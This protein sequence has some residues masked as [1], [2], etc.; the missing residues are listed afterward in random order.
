MQGSTLEE[1][2]ETR[3][4]RSSPLSEPCRRCRPP[5]PVCAGGCTDFQK[6]FDVRAGDDDDG[7]L[8]PPQTQQ[9]QP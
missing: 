3:L 9:Q 6:A 1:I 2:S 7:S 8:Q 4:R 5:R